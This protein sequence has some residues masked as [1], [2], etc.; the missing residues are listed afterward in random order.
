MITNAQKRLAK[1]VTTIPS[2]RL[3]LFQS[4]TPYRPGNIVALDCRSQPLLCKVPPVFQVSACPF[5]KCPDAP[6]STLLHSTLLCNTLLY[7]TLPYPTLLYSTLIYYPLCSTLL[8]STLLYPTLTEHRVQS[9][10]YT[11]PSTDYSVA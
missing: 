3:S 2:K 4:A 7:S 6:Y 11:V 8:Y 5:S 10:E 9:R 1:S